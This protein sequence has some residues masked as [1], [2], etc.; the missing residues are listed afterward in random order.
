MKTGIL[1]LGKFMFATFVLISCVYCSLAFTSYTYND[2]FDDNIIQAETVINAPAYKVFNYLGQSSN[3]KIWSTYVEN[4]QP[5]NEHIISDGLMGSVR[6]CFG[7]TKGVIWDER[8]IKVQAKKSRTLS[9][10]NTQGFFMTA[11]HLITDQL[12]V[13]KGHQTKLILTLRFNK[14]GGDR[15]SRLKMFLASPIVHR[16]FE[17]N[18]KNIKSEN[19]NRQC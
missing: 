5:I 2:S 13:A 12:Y 14:K 15:F 4:I 18:L 7:K 9:I 17:N 11:P 19:E 1:S 10:F 8:I 16:I 6:R 3:A